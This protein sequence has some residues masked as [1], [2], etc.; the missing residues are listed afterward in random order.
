MY[1]ELMTDFA[2]TSQASA[3]GGPLE[4][5]HVLSLAT[6]VRQ[7]AGDAIEIDDPIFPFEVTP[8]NEHREAVRAA[9]EVM[10]AEPVVTVGRLVRT[11]LREQAGA[12]DALAWMLDTGLLLRS[13]PEPESVALRSV[14]AQMGQPL[15]SIQGVSHTADAIVIR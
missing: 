9:L 11:H 12:R 2:G 10:R 14:G 6:P 13:R 5:L 7:T 3:T 8:P 1:R 15:F 4:N